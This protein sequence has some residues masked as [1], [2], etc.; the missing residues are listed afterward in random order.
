MALLKRQLKYFNLSTKLWCS[1]DSWALEQTLLSQAASLTQSHSRCP[2]PAVSAAGFPALWLHRPR[3]SPAPS[4][5]WS[6][7]AVSWG[8]LPLFFPESFILSRAI[9]LLSFPYALAELCIVWESWVPAWCEA[10][11]KILPSGVAELCS[12]WESCPSESLFAASPE[13]KQCSVGFCLAS[14]AG[15]AIAGPPSQAVALLGLI[16]WAR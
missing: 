11:W 10:W 6:S 9:C 1:T 13:R 7:C 16:S 4:A 8:L 14:L 12:M 2:T 5:F 15:G 3:S